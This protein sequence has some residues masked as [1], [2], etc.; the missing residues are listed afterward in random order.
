MTWDS[1]FSEPGRVPFQVPSSAQW[2]V[3]REVLSKKFESVTGKGLSPQSLDFLGK[4][5]FRS[6]LDHL[7]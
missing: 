5:L 4:K 1:A 7:T 3:V 6:V 2:E